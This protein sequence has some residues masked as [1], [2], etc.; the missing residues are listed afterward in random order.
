MSAIRIRRHSISLSP[1][2]A[3]VIIRPFVPLNAQRIATI[4]G[5][6][7]SLSDEEVKRE[8]QTVY[9]EFENR[10]FDIESQL[11][12]NYAKVKPHVFTQRPL[13]HERELLLGAI[14]SGEYAL[15]SA[16]LFNP[17]IVPHPDQTKLPNGSLRFI[18]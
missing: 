12:I 4:M 8:L 11:L 9:A 15:E 7:L 10:H 6:A 3:R 2:S 17:S 13:S 16:A 1:D 5:R 14:F 18:V